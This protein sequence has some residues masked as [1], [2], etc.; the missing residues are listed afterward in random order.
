MKCISLKSRMVFICECVHTKK[1]KQDGLSIDG[2][3]SENDNFDSENIVY[4]LE[5]PLFL[6]EFSILPQKT[7]KTQ[8]I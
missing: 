5:K 2:C 8:T 3:T 6:S 1:L 7:C 4:P